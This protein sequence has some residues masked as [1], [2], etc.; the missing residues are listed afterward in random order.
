MDGGEVRGL[1][2]VSSYSIEG[3]CC[4]EYSN[5]TYYDPPEFGGC[6]KVSSRG[7]WCGNG[8]TLTPSSDAVPC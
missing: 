4:I 5:T 2:Q 3:G 7:G 6:M 8:T 1:L